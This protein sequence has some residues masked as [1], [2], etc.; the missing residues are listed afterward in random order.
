MTE[1]SQT[2]GRPAGTTVVPG[3]ANVVGVG[4]VGGSVGMALRAKGWF[5][6]A[7]DIDSRIQ[8]E[9]I[10]RQVADEVGFDP[11]ADITFVAVPVGSIPELAGQA[12]DK[13]S[14]IVTDVGSTKAEIC[15]AVVDPR[16]VGGHPMAGS[17]QDGLQGARADLFDGAMWVLTPSDTTSQEAFAV[18]RAVVRSLGAETISLAAPVHDE[19]VAQVSHVPHLTAAALM[20]LAA[21]GSLQ[22]RA[23]LRLAAGGF[24]DMTRISAGGPSIWPDICVA[25]STA[26][27][28]S[29]DDLITQLEQTRSLV[30]ARDKVGLYQFFDQARVA[31][32]NLPVGYGEV[33]KVAEVVV[34][35]PDRPGELAAITTLAAELDVNILDLELSHSG[36]GRRGL[37]TVV[38]EDDLA[39]RLVGGLMVRQY[40]PSI[41]RPSEDESDSDG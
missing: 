36:E 41:R 20:N 27:A 19:L 26:I 10:D 9:A 15:R 35:I 16:F 21:S 23:L 2:N 39:E 1:T 34:P 31:R 38:V 28:Q 13:T 4:L 32:L 11:T 5:V 12:L 25:N 24:R 29:L 33:D 14:G 6:T 3:R 8:A 40:Q 17:E 22:H 7:S 37:L 30:E 18:V